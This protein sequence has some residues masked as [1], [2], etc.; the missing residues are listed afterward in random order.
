M[1]LALEGIRRR[2]PDEACHPFHA[3]T[4]T[5]RDNYV[6]SHTYRIG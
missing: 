1:D 2:I 4:A 5:D 6:T 3:N